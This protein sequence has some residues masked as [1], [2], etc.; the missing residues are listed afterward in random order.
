M[1]QGYSM[2]RV[3]RR[4]LR[5]AAGSILSIAAACDERQTG[6]DER[7]CAFRVSLARAGSSPNGHGSTSGRMGTM[8]QDRRAAPDRTQVS[9]IGSIIYIM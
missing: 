9:I 7:S 5:S 6:F 3:K 8:S 4:P 1:A 2:E